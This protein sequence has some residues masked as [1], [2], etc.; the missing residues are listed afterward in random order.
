MKKRKEK[1]EKEKKKDQL[2]QI[3]NDIKLQR[4]DIIKKKEDE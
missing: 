2:E 1:K 3:K 4:E